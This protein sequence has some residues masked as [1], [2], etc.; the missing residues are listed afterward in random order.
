MNNNVNNWQWGQHAAAV[1][2]GAF[3]TSPSRGQH[4]ANFDRNSVIGPYR[5]YNLVVRDYLAGNLS[6]SHSPPAYRGT[7]YEHR[8]N[9]SSLIGVASRTTAYPAIGTV[10]ANAADAN[11]AVRGLSRLDLDATNRGQGPTWEDAPMDMV[12]IYVKGD[13]GSI[14]GPPFNLHK[15]FFT[16]L[17]PYFDAVFNSS[18]V[19]SA[20][21]TLH[22]AESNR[23]IF[24]M[25]I[26]WV[27]KKQLN[28]LAAFELD[29]RKNLPVGIGLST[30]QGS[31]LDKYISKSQKTAFE[32][33]TK[34]I[35]L[36]F[37]ADKVL[38]PELQNAAIQA[39]ELLRFFTP[40]QGV[41]AEISHAVYDKTTKDSP[42]RKYLAYTT[43]LRLHPQ[44]E[45]KGKD[46]HPDMLVD[47][48]DIV[49]VAGADAKLRHYGLSEKAMESFL[50]EVKGGSHL[51]ANPNTVA[52]LADDIWVSLW[53]VRRNALKF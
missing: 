25:L 21:Q 40:L 11:E 18:F 2:V 16:H 29:D 41:P 46:F 53:E 23:G 3:S 38:M 49:K 6:T 1:P 10:S 7:L 24:A 36:W 15:Y 43:L 17:S 22:F 28:T 44:S 5:S 8:A 9:S 48:F 39:I 42:I 14:D 45:D 12:T 51:K 47:I 26:D 50:V 31:D 34:L 52:S 4:G 19:E 37:L 30:L 33:T 27:Y 20:T 13:D 35:D 32:H